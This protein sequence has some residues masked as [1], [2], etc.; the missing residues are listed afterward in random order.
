MHFQQSQHTNTH[1]EGVL[2]RK[3]G[4]KPKPRVTAPKSS[5]T[6][7]VSREEQE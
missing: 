5:K 7:R 6:Q 3:D 2:E 1:A 4:N